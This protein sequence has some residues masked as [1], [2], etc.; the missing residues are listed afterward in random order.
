MQ[1][2]TNVVLVKKMK[3]MQMKMKRRYTARTWKMRLKQLKIDW[4]MME[5]MW[6]K[7]MKMKTLLLLFGI[8]VVISEDE[9][10]KA[11]LDFPGED[12]GIAVQ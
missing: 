10:L 8:I 5:R 3:I 9:V 2:C 1:L 7:A 12:G 4:M 6:K 11:E